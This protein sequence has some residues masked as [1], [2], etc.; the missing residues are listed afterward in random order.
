MLGFGFTQGAQDGLWLGVFYP[1]AAG[2]GTAGFIFGDIGMLQI[3]NGFFQNMADFAAGKIRVS[4][5]DI[6]AI[7]G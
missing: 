5:N 2:L 3:G 7:L 1:Q 4:K 6:A